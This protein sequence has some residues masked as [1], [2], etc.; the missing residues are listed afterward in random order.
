MKPFIE[1]AIP[2]K[3]TGDRTF[4]NGKYQATLKRD[5]D[6]ITLAIR[7]EDRR[8]II[9]WRDVQWIKNQILGPEVEAVQLFPAE[10]RLVDTS[11]QYYLFANAE[12]G[13]RF[14]F[15]F[16][17][18][19]VTENIT[20]QLRGHG[21]SRQRPFADHVRPQDLDECQ[22]RGAEQLRKMGWKSE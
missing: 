17:E 10:S 3:G 13:Y 5:G 19:M 20:L 4:Y 1:G 16:T 21:K 11:N 14:P 22:Q 18:R 8:P 15:G 12:P 6:L 2:P 7:R 9:D